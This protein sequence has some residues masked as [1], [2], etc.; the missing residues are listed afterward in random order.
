MNGKGGTAVKQI[1][2]AIENGASGPDETHT[3]RKPP[4]FMVLPTRSSSLLAW[5]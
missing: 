4:V 3:I 2:L 5:T 1:L